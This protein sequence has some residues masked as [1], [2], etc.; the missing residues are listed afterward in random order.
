MKKFCITNYGFRIFY[1][2]FFICSCLQITAQDSIKTNPIVYADMLIGHSWMKAGGFTVGAGLHYQKNQHL[3]NIRFTGTVK[4]ESGFLSPIIPIPFVDEKSSLE[5]FSL[6]YGWRII[7]GGMSHS[8]SFGISHNKFREVVFD[9]F[10]REYTKTTK[11]MGVPFEANIKWFNNEKKRYRIYYLIPVGKPT[12]FSRSIGAR[13]YGN[14]SKNSY[15]GLGM[16]YGF[17]FHKMY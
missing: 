15:F 3:F 6:L 8:Y 12:G 9:D 7:N 5:E 13:F 4:L 11:Y 17:G 1:V 2:F 14:I 16:I 10:N